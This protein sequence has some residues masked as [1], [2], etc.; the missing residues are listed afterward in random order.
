MVST[1]MPELPEVET[2][3]RS[4]NHHVPGRRII[5]VQTGDFSGVLGDNPELTAASLT[6]RVIEVIQRRGKYLLLRLD[7]GS[8]VVIHL[9]MTGQ[10]LLT[11]HEHPTVRFQHLAI[12]LDNGHDLRFADQRKFGRVLHVSEETVKDLDHRL[13]PEPLASDFSASTLAA[14]LRRR[15][16]KIKS[17]ILDQHVVAG[18]GNI[19]ADEALFRA[20][21]HPERSASSLT[22][23]EISRLHRAIRSSLREA[24]ANRG[25]TFSSFV[26]G[27]GA[28]G[29][30]AQHLRVYGRGR[31]G[32]ACVRCGGAL[33]LTL[34]GGRSSHFCPNC[35][36]ATLA[37][38]G[39]TPPPHEENA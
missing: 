15:P 31:R 34:V 39:P 11:S 28:S 7:D 23:P 27:Y 24:V 8:Y 36:P 14:A 12:S 18:L 35:Q 1:S 6:D 2:V 38:A 29:S 33:T 13:G 16:G 20:G 10:L 17:V 21:I 3:R 30:N 4:L 19:Y 26:D 5:D 9:R 25:T 37:T 22:A 32:E